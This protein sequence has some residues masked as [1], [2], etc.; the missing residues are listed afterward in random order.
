MLEVITIK[1]QP[2]FGKEKQ[3][4]IFSFPANFIRLSGFIRSPL[5]FYRAGA[6][7]VFSGITAGRAPIPAFAE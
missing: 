2:S 7:G 3:R 4:R 1:V 6:L 5:P